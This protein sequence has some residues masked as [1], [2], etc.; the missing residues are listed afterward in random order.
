VQSRVSS[1]QKRHGYEHDRNRENP[2]DSTSR[3][4]SNATKWG[5]FR[6]IA[7]ER[8]RPSGSRPIETAIAMTL[9]DLSETHGLLMVTVSDLARYRVESEYE[10]SLWAADASLVCV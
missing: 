3:H 2:D 9:G 7:Y 8:V 6:T 1:I 10:R 5:V 4:H